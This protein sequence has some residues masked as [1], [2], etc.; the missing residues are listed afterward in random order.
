MERRSLAYQGTLTIAHLFFFK[1]KTDK[2]ENKLDYSK[3]QL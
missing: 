3:Q 1:E 2:W